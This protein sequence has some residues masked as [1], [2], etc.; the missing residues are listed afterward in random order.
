MQAVMFQDTRRVEVCQVSDATIQDPGD[1]VMRI[2]SSAICGTDLHMYDGRTGAQP[3]LVLGLGPLGVI[4]QVGDG[5]GLLRPGQRV[6]EPTI[7][8][9]GCASIAS[10]AIPPPACGWDLHRH[11]QGNLTVAL[12]QPQPWRKAARCQSQ[13]CPLR[14]CH[15]L[16]WL[17]ALD[18]RRPASGAASGPGPR[19]S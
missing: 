16:D 18:P 15:S 8:C 12:V 17:S 2:T 3:G 14:L 13:A 4:E 1:M 9:A 5:V 10:A 11:E 6:V 19:G 7:C